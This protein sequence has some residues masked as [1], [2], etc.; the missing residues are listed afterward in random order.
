MKSVWTLAL[1][2]ALFAGTAQAQEQAQETYTLVL[3][4]NEFHPKTLELPAGKKVKLIVENQDKTPAEFES[5]D[6]KLEKIITGGGKATMYVRPLKKG[7]YVFFDEFHE[8]TTRGQV[9]VK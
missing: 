9:V 1:C 3:K 8:K 2:A 7:T 5:H 4:N 6:L